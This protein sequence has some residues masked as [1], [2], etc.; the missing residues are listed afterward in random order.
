MHGRVPGYSYGQSDLGDL[1]GPNDD[2][3][4]CGEQYLCY[5]IVFALDT[6]S[7]YSGTCS[8]TNA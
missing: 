8:L 6:R 2:I 7:G 4:Y 3:Y 5:P 1:P